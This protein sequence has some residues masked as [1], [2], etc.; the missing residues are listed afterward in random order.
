MLGILAIIFFAELD[1]KVDLL[2]SLKMVLI[3]DLTEAVTGDIPAFEI[4]AR[5]NGKHQAEKDALSYLVT[6]L[7]K[8]TA[9]E[10]VSLWEE[11]EERRTPEAKFA[12]S[13]DALEVLM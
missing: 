4:S 9:H 2:K 5:Q 10:I 8:Q 3:H 1:T 6:S 12:N 13:L 11:F 7:P